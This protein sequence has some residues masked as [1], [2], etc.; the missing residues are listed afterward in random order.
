MSACVSATRFAI[1]TGEPQETGPCGGW[2]A[3]PM[4]L[5]YTKVFNAD[6]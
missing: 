6:H 5:R 2:Q 4:L 3:S 1:A